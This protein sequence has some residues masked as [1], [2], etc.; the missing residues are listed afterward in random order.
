LFRPLLTDFEANRL[1]YIVI[2]AIDGSDFVLESNSFTFIA[3]D[4]SSLIYCG[5]YTDVPVVKNFGLMF[6][7]ENGNFL[8]L[9]Q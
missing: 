9:N 3:R 6:E 8:T 7:L 1:Y 2:D 5:G 4:I